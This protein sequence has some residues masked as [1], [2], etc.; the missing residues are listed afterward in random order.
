[1]SPEQDD[2]GAWFITLPNGER[3][4]FGSN[5]E[6]WRWLDR[7]ERRETW[8]SSKAQWRMPAKYDAP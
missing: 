7:H 6:A 5:A 2:K 3:A 8:V 4:E 1:M